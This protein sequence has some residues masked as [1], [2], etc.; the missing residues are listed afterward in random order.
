MW[1]SW[2]VAGHNEQG[3]VRFIDRLKR[4]HLDDACKQDTGEGV[5]KFEK[6]VDTKLNEFCGEEWSKWNFKGKTLKNFREAEPFQQ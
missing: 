2:I 4:K 3:L 6:E 1:S 5:R